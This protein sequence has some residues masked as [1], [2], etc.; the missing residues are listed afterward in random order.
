MS[1]IGGN[2]TA[3]LPLGLGALLLSTGRWKKRSFVNY[4]ELN[5]HC[6]LGGMNSC[7]LVEHFL[8]PW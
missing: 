1:S 7:K 4:R 3:M 6:K 8:L 5:K 2:F